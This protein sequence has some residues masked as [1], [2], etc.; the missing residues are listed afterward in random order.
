MADSGTGQEYGLVP[1]NEASNSHNARTPV[2]GNA[3]IAV[4]ITQVKESIPETV[5]SFSPR[6]AL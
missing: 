5:K 2:N 1:K 6:T 4:Q 3:D